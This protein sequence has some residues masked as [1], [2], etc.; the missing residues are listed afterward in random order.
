MAVEAGDRSWG[1]Q[2]ESVLLQVIAAGMPGSEGR[3]QD[4][5]LAL[6]A[7]AAAGAW[8]VRVHSCGCRDQLP[9]HV[10]KWGLATEAWASIEHLC[11]RRGQGELLMW[12]PGHAWQCQLEQQ[13]GWGGIQADGVCKCKTLFAFVKSTG[14]LQH[15]CWLLVS[16]M[17][18]AA[19]VLCRAVHWVLPRGPQ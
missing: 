17:A 2:H 10:W 1:W 5:G 11:G 8:A 12:I 18:K 7:G 3:W 19:R 15:L 4:V 13:M 14:R 16:A 6:G 9:V